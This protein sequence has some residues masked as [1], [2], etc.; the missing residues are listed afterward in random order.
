MTRWILAAALA[1]TAPTVSDRIVHVGDAAIRIVCGGDRPPGAPLVVL[2]A[3]AGN[4]ADTWSKGQ[5]AIAEFARVCAYDRPTLVRHD[6]TRPPAPT[7]DAV[8]ATLDGVL[9]KAG[10]RPPYVLVGHSYGGMIVRLYAMRF[11]DRVAGMV[12]I[13]SSHED[14]TRRFAALNPG[15]PV[16]RP[17]LA[18]ESF[19]L[20]AMSDA[21]SAR[22]WHADIPLLVLTRAYQPSGPRDQYDVWLDLQRELATRSPKARHIVAEHA[23]HYIHNDEPQL[24]IA[25]VRQMLATR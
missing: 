4:G 5:P 1:I 3:G 20:D 23:G 13:D 24:V 6:A 11:P 19:D 9:T 12:L 17:A 14:Q 7:P 10:E 2:E 8:L 22:P 16:V 21:L 18:A 15:Q 25:G